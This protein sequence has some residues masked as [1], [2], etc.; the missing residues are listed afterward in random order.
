MAFSSASQKCHEGRLHVCLLCILGSLCPMKTYLYELQSGLDNC[1]T[2]SFVKLLQA[3]Q[4]RVTEAV[5][6]R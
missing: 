3:V 5:L 4:Y 2:G 6:Q 1:S